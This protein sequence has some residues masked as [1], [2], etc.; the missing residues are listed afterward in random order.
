MTMIA[1]LGDLDTTA[2]PTAAITSVNEVGVTY[3]GIP[4]AIVGGAT[5][6]EVHYHGDSVYP[7]TPLGSSLTVTIAGR[8]VHRIGDLRSCGV[9]FT[10]TKIIG[11]V[12]TVNIFA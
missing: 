6:T 4:I 8:P 9:H 12:R 7:A 1:L 2:E 3:M 11:E 5:A 10:V